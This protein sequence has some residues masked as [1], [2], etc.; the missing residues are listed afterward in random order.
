MGTPAG[1]AVFSNPKFNI[2]IKAVLDKWGTFLK[3]PESCGTLNDSPTGW[4]GLDSH[5]QEKIHNFDD[6]FMCDP[7]KP[8]KGFTSW[9]DFFT[10]RFRSGLRPIASPEDDNVI[11]NACESSPY[12]LE[13]GVAYQARFWMKAQPYSLASLL[14]VAGEKKEEGGEGE[15]ENSG[16]TGGMA[17]R[18]I[19]GTIYQVLQKGFIS[20]VIPGICFPSHH[21]SFS[22]FCHYRPSS[23]PL[24]T[25]AGTPQSTELSIRSVTYQVHTMQSAPS[26]WTMKMRQTTAKPSS[27]KW[28]LE[29]SCTSQQI[30]LI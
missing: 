24:R 14:D 9:D 20:L 10:R 22:F 16:D 19:G 21:F 8:H 15:R 30:I 1:L 12:R 26:K 17:E 6:T 27:V 2:A 7:T 3:S 4:F 23:L 25:T 18:F 5:G 11:C 13:R 28:L 29:C